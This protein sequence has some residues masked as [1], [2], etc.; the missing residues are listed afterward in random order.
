MKTSS[1]RLFL[2][3]LCVLI[4]F[5]LTMPGAQ[6]QIRAYQRLAFRHAPPALYLTAIALPGKTNDTYQLTMAFRINHKM[7][8]FKK[9]NKAGNS[10][11][12]DVP[13]LSIQVYKLPN[14][15]SDDRIKLVDL[16]SAARKTWSDTV[17]AQGYEATTDPKQFANGFIQMQLPPGSYT[18]ILKFRE[19]PSNT[20][21]SARQYITLNTEKG[22][23]ILSDAV[24]KSDDK[25]DRLSVI[26]M[27]NNVP[28]RKDF[29]AFIRLPDYDTGKNYELTVHQL[30]ID[31]DDTTMVKTVFESTIDDENIISSVQP[32]MA[33]QQ[34]R[35]N[36]QLQQNGENTYALIQVPNHQF[37]DDAYKI[38]VVETGSDKIAAQKTFRS[39]WANK[40][41]S[42][43]DTD[44]AINMLRFITDEQTIDKIDDGSTNEK[45]EKLNA[46]WEERDPTP[47]TE[48]NE[49][50]V[51]YYR[52]IDYAF[53]N[54]SGQRKPGIETDRGRIYILYGP[55]DDIERVFPT[56]GATREIWTYPNRQFVFEATSGFGDF[57]LVK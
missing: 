28:Y 47:N 49:L 17:Y 22:D 39:L 13:S 43:Y 24:Q 7:L 44:L 52:R 53:R 45:R 14:G 54:Y 20:R 33:S 4:C 51:E 30:K 37:V 31:D 50:K 56:E 16:E 35:L 5:L 36:I 21:T 41:I 10:R 26:N 1:R 57:V 32:V 9:L 18:Y 55:P 40:P 11:F 6:A 38:E 25:I 46:F 42:L 3:L 27:G 12:F 2:R 19:N 34:D 15:K 23:I 29:Y 8:S 48:Y